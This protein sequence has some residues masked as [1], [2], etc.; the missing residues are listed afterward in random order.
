MSGSFNPP[1]TST[2]NV[3]GVTSTRRISVVTSPAMIAPWIAAPIATASIGSIPLSGSF[4][5]TF[6]MN[7]L[8]MGI[9]VGPPIKIIFSMSAA[10]SFASS[11]ACN[12][13]ALHLSTIGLSNSSNFDLERV[14]T[15]FLGPVDGS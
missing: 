7:C 9:R 4:P 2:P 1:S 5:I 10:F 8:T 14:K 12:M 11:M 13:G 6:V 3:R 15:K